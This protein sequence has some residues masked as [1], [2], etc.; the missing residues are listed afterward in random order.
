MPSLQPETFGDDTVPIAIVGM[1]CRFPGEATNLARFWDMMVNG[2]TGHSAIPE[3]RFNADA[4]YHPNHERKGAIQP[5][6][7][8]FLEESP[9]VFDAPFFSMTA[10][11]AAGM[12]PMQRKL[13]EIAYE[14]FENAGIPM[15]TLPGSATGVYSGVMTNDYELMTAGDAMQLPQN[16]ASGTSRAMLS[17]RISWFFD[18]RGPSFALDTAC[19][20]SLYALHLACQSLQT[21]ETNQALVTGVNLILAPNFIS[22]LSSMHMLSPDG[23]SHSFDSRANGYARGEALAAVVVKTLSQAIADGDTIRAVIRGTG[24]NQDGKTVGITIPNG[25]A[26]ADLIHNVY[27]AAG[28]DLGETGYFESHGTGTP[29]GDPIELAAIGNSFGTNRS[30]ENPLIV[31]SVKA[32]IGHTEGAAGLAGIIKT[33]LVLEQGVIPPLPDF[34]ELNPKLD[35][36]SWNLTLPLKLCPW[37]TTGLRRAS[38][39]SFGFGGANAHVILDD[40]HHYLLSHGLRGQYLKVAPE[41]NSPADSGLSITSMESHEDSTGKGDIPKLL[42]FSMYDVAGM[43][44]MEASFTDFLVR[45]MT[46]TGERGA[47]LSGLAYTLYNRRTVFDFRS[48][49]VAESISTLVTKLKDGLPKFSRAS[50]HTSP[51]FVFTG[52]GAQ[53][54]AMGRELLSNSVFRSS[55]ESSQATLHRVGC[56]WNVFELLSDPTD[57]R[58]DLPSFSQPVCTILQV[59]LVDLLQYWGIKP[60]ATVGH[61]SGEVAAAYA[62]G[63]ISQEEAVRIGYWRGF[64][65][66][67]VKNENKECK[68]A[69][70]AVGLSETNVQ[71]YLSA[72]PEGAVV[73]GCIN[74]PSSV[75]LSGDSEAIDHLEALI[76]N[77]GHFARK[78][79]VQVAYHSHHMQLVADAFLHALGS[80]DPKQSDIPMFSSV[81]EQL[82]EEPSMLRAQYWMQ[83]L[84]SP[85]RF[86]GALTNLLGYS[87]RGK[88]RRRRAG[89]TQW[90]ALVEVG[91]HEALK[92]PC[93][94]IMSAWDSS[95]PDKIPYLAIL[96]RGKNSRE[97]A[98]AAAGILWA[99]GHGV[100]LQ[101][102]NEHQDNLQTMSADL[103]PYAW[104]HEKEFWHE[105]AMSASARLRNEP[106]NDL[107]G[108][109]VPL[110]NP[111]ERHWRNYLSVS[112]CPWQADHVITGTVLYPGA[113]HLIM[114]VEAA[115]RLADTEKELLG[116]EFRDVHFS[117]GLVIPPIDQAV[118]TLLTT[119]PH[120]TLPGWYHYTVYSINSTASWTKHS[121]GTIN[122]H[123]EDSLA[124]DQANNYCQTYQN[125]R[126]QAS[127]PLNIASFYNQLQSIGTE[128]GPTFR[129]VIE[130]AVV[131]GQ[132]KGVGTIIVADTK[133]VM[134][135]GF[136]YPHLI[137]PTTLDAFFHLIFVAMGQGEPLLESAIPTTIG[138]L[139]ISTGLPFKA[140]TKYSGFSHAEPL[141]GRDTLGSIVISDENWSSRPKIIVEG[142]VITEVSSGAGSPASSLSL[143]SHGRISTLDWKEDLDAL[144]GS[145]AE[146]WLAQESVRRQSTFGITA[147]VSQLHEWLS[148]AC[149]KHTDWK[150]LIVNPSNWSH[151]AFDILEHFATKAGERYRFARTSIIES[152][153][154][155]M[156]QIQQAL[157]SLNVNIDYIMPN[158]EEKEDLSSL[159]TFDL[160]LA[161]F[162]CAERLLNV[163]SLIRHEGKV[164]L[165]TTSRNDTENDMSDESLRSNA[166]SAA[167]LIQTVHVVSDQDD[168]ELLIA[169]RGP[170]QDPLDNLS[171]IV[172]VQRCNPSPDAKA[173][174]ERL[175][176]R[177]STPGRRVWST[178]LSG[179][180]DLSGCTV[181]SL[182]ESVNPFVISWTPEDFE[183]FR[184][185]TAAK[186]V[187]WITR[188]G[189]LEAGEDSLKYAPSTGLLRT[190]RVEKPQIRLP[191]LDLS[192][193]G[194]RSADRIVD[195]ILTVFRLSIKEPSSG[196][197]NDMEYA[198]FDG[199][200]WIPRAKAHNGLDHELSLYAG[201]TTNVQGPL[202][203]TSMSRKLETYREGNSTNFR[204]VPDHTQQCTLA[205]TEI[206]IQPSHIS[207][208][209]AGA[210]TS[211]LVNSVLSPSDPRVG[212]A[213][214]VMQVGS[215]VSNFVA[216]DKVLTLQRNPF[217]T[218]LRSL[219][220]LVHKVPT[221]LSLAEVAIFPLA[222][223]H[224]WHTLINISQFRAGKSVFVSGAAS[225]FGQ[226]LIQLVQLLK[227][228]VFISVP[229]ER[230]VKWLAETYKLPP[231]HIFDE[232]NPNKWPSGILDATNGKGLDIIINNDARALAIRN[233]SVSIANNGKFVD[234]TQQIEPSMLAPGILKNGV[235]LISPD[236]DLPDAE[237]FDLVKKAL[238]LVNIGCLRQ[239]HPIHQFSVSD[240]DEAVVASNE[241]QSLSSVVVEF[242]Q[243][244]KVVLLPPPPPPLELNPS[245]TYILAGGL[246]ALGLTIA[247]NMCIHG[248]RHLVFL[249]RSGASS[250]R[251]QKALQCLRSQGCEVEVI[252]CDVTDKEQ[253]LMLAKVIQEKNWNL[254][255]IIQLAMVLRDSIFENMTFDKWQTAVDPKIKG[256]WHLHSYLPKELDFFIILS[257][258]SG[259]I[260]NTAQ[261]NYSAGNTYEDALAHYRRK[262]GLVA[263]TL[264]VGLV[265]DADH[266]NEDN[267]V[268][269]YL[270]KFSHWI[271][272]QVTDKELQ[273]TLIAVMRGGLADGERVPDQLLVGLSDQVR[274]DGESLNLWPM[275]RKFD[276]RISFS[277]STQTVKND[278]HAQK[279]QAVQTMVEAQAIVEEA[280]RLNVANAMTASPD[281]ID[282]EKPLYSFGIDSLKAIEVRNW[283]FNELKADISVFEILSPIPL[284]QL[285]MSIISKS[286]IV[287]QGVVEVEEG[288]RKT[289][290]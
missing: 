198:E 227:G 196:A 7:G 109:P 65:S 39:N 220:S 253:V 249:S 63:F 75:T 126:S 1:A 256:T 167:N 178:T 269:D 152:S 279:L 168:S 67:R 96:N 59:A 159:G 4:W 147:A 72:V 8:F 103:P 6:S 211:S 209:Q 263:T 137:H 195:N 36:D 192:P 142:M 285:A 247:N 80:V 262:L 40:A 240:L 283:I 41:T 50:R 158:V 76:R 154:E 47:L 26:Q 124:Q 171:E 9:A 85:V 163:A 78:L 112:E 230:D 115:Q 277:D 77:D 57:K 20:S 238:D 186:Y 202:Y 176:A 208:G 218:H 287:P 217:H 275:D 92:G 174:E 33:V 252:R 205:D 12:D 24:A 274:R 134:P 18:L 13:L 54:P 207:L 73:V 61:S 286:S 98:L 143:S 204:W 164:A 266:F 161:P 267:T 82:I 284:S 32:N 173:F 257:S 123:Y 93:K 244:A 128:Y 193:S 104:N 117:K 229:F 105:P 106:R 30:R 268:E 276:H 191:H 56:E 201:T 282:V 48:F 246:G 270:R 55:I 145:A 272:A 242:S 136:E 133:S 139:F 243:E 21:G 15:H 51:V 197:N 37:P 241:G 44:R 94:Q 87:P 182:L 28:L 45:D 184:Q 212:V 74:S 16:A 223:A 132:H 129:N 125:L 10:N 281:D 166:L 265:I 206:L 100:D 46:S 31:G 35:L 11:E 17:N 181:I 160:V 107:L 172:I 122:L 120:D 200:L 271:P 146:S 156:N 237:L 288:E 175:I 2:R 3:D 233:L 273:N 169:T 245:A 62:A 53:W 155:A 226:A 113:G 189:I 180:S 116:V 264:N 99:S 84:V 150:V 157:E 259:I 149:F 278:S 234:V 216:G 127:Q 251:Q 215:C 121:W 194:D 151:G 148:L 183:Q 42:V 213:G 95:D 49:A 177:L 29:V 101:R 222:A 110:Q 111:F 23:K 108:M 69:M 224:A 66:E 88:A 58:I 38:V 225:S 144:M 289:S 81:T 214:V 162:C 188:G 52:Q 248:A 43:R 255:G 60:G 34:R 22:Q 179:A 68:G 258:L 232:S 14:A 221:S 190:V 235:S 250:L 119:R 219:E 19:S 90:S 138:R 135:H 25:K 79:R 5:R 231:N 290:D 89:V 199:R 165:V 261:A 114:A 86:S 280:L 27:A 236:F 239:I 102:V 141:T 187:L 131:P 228:E 118:E 130:A 140:G 254:R 203:H 64:Y 260:G 70:M 91:P 210:K 97:T 153:E 71:E 185:L 170:E 83:N